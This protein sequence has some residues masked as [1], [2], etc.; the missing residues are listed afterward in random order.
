MY[1]LGWVVEE[2]GGERMGCGEIGVGWWGGE[3]GCGGF[4]IGGIIN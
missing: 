2:G 4:V 3:E 1:W